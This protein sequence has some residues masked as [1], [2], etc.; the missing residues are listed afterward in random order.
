MPIEAAGL[1]PQFRTRGHYAAL[2]RELRFRPTNGEER[3]EDR[4]ETAEIANRQPRQSIAARLRQLNHAHSDLLSHDRLGT[5]SRASREYSGFEKDP[6]SF[7]K[8][9]PSPAA[10][11]QHAPEQIPPDNDWLS[12]P[13]R[14]VISGLG[15]GVSSYRDIPRS[16]CPLERAGPGQMT[17]REDRRNGQDSKRD[18]AV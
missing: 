8:G 6:L 14:C 11:T 13:C 1:L 2:K 3:F 15:A 18:T 10:T 17:L 7:E 16:I 9:T 5:P 4:L 12:T